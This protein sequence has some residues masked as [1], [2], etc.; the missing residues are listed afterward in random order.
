MSMEI[1]GSAALVFLKVLKSSF[2]E[3]DIPVAKTKVWT[4]YLLVSTIYTLLIDVRTSMLQS[5][6]PQRFT[7]NKYL[8]S[9]I[10]PFPRARFDA[11][12]IALRT[13]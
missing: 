8:L 7:A 12:A 6:F 4:M 1:A 9:G 5:P 3:I 10:F 11:S 2:I 13:K